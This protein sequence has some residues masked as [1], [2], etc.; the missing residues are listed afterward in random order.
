VVLCSSIG[1]KLGE[2]DGVHVVTGGFFGVGDTVGRSYDLKRRELGR[3]SNIWH[4]LPLR[5]AKVN[6]MSDFIFVP[7]IIFNLNNSQPSEMCYR[8]F[9]S[10]ELLR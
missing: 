7:V 1:E 4:V 8:M 9:C 10:F 2:L 6:K 3:T 5:D